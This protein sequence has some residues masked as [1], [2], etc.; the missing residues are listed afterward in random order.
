MT[1][2]SPVEMARMAASIDLLS[3]GRFVLGMGAGWNEPEHTAYGIPFPERGERS[4]RL[5]E[6]VSVVR[7]LWADGPAT[8]DGRYYHLDGAN[9]M[10]KPAAGRPWLLVGGS[11]PLR[12]LK[13]AAQHA[14][15]WNSVN[16]PLDRY[17]ERIATLESHCATF[18]RDPASIKRSM[19]T[20]ALVGP[21]DAAVQHAAEVTAMQMGRGRGG[22]KEL[23][24]TAAER[25][26]LHG[27]TDQVVDQL[28]KLAELGVS[29]VQ[30]QH[31]DFDDDAVPQ[32]LAE[33]IVPRVKDL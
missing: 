20:F 2:R 3:D 18:D 8:F 4:G 7:A 19:M 12:T 11:G 15:E 13:V 10:P 31:L 17:A 6:A 30:F 28:G 1:F 24:D 5:V 25:G 21:T 23:L 26:V 29:E 33:E 32:F 14:D 27:T 9:M 22:A 16:A